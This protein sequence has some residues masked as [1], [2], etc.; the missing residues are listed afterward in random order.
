MLREDYAGGK[1][2]ELSETI[3]ELREGRYHEGKA[4]VIRLVLQRI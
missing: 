4:S 1:I 2:L 3:I